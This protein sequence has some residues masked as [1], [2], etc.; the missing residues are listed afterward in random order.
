MT[1]LAWRPTEVRAQT[2]GSGL[3]I[4]EAPTSFLPGPPV[5]RVTLDGPRNTGP[6]AVIYLDGQRRDSTALGSLNPNDIASVSVVKAATARLLGPDEARLGV[7]IITTK[8]G[9]H[10]RAVR[11]FTKRLAKLART[12]ANLPAN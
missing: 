1:L 2:P 9:Q 11:A 4:Q 10:T 8:A 5:K 3:H 7:L 12:Q 6:L